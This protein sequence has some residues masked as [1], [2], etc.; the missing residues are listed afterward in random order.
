MTGL[1]IVRLIKKLLIITRFTSNNHWA[2]K[3]WLSGVN[4]ACDCSGGKSMDIC[5]LSQAG[6]QIEN[7]LPNAPQICIVIKE[8]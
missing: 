4:K 1:P 8:Q 6:N 5:S 7:G 2:I 3:S